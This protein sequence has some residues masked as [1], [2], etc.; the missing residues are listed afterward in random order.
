[1]IGLLLF[2]LRFCLSSESS[3]PKSRGCSHFYLQCNEYGWSR[4]PVHRQQR[5]ELSLLLFGRLA[6]LSQ[7]MLLTL[8]GF[9]DWVFCVFNT[10]LL[11]IYVGSSLSRTLALHLSSLSVPSVSSSSHSSRSLAY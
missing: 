4:W 8:I 1:M 2:S 10:F 7:S 9:I 11:Y 6:P 3:S 5:A